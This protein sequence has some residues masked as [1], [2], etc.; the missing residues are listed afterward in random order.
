MRCYGQAV[1]GARRRSRAGRGRRG[2]Q[3]PGWQHHRRSL[4]LLLA[5]G[6]PTLLW[7]KGEGEGRGGSHGSLSIMGRGEGLVLRQNTHVLISNC[8]LA[9][10]QARP[11]LVPLSPSL[12]Q[13][14]ST[15]VLLSPLPSPVPLSPPPRSQPCPLPPSSPPPPSPLTSHSRRLQWVAQVAVQCA[16]GGVSAHHLLRPVTPRGRLRRQVQGGSERDHR[17]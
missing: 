9:E 15:S 11:I 12:P 7:C 4:G 8:M 16:G 3:A 2:A 1:R 13:I 5:A 6:Q 14:R 10:R 17:D